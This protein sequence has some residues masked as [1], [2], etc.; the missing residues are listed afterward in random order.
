MNNEKTKECGIV[1]QE[2]YASIPNVHTHKE[3][4]NGLSKFAAW[5]GKSAD[6]ILAMRKDDLKL[7][8][9]FQRKRFE[10]ELEKFHAHLKEDG[11]STNTARTMCLGL[12]QFFNFY[13]VGMKLKRGSNVGKTV[14]TD[15]GYPLTIEDLRRMFA[16][17]SLRERVIL[18][19]AKDLGVRIG[20]FVEIRRDQLPD[21]NQEAPISFDVMTGK[22][23]V[24][25]KGHLSAETVEILKI[26][27]P[28]IQTNPNPH[29]FPT[30][31]THGI[32]ED[33]LG[34]ILKNLAVKAGILIPKTKQLTFHSFRKLFISTGKNVG[35]SDDIVKVLCGKSVDSDILTYMTGIQW[36]E[37]FAKI[38]DA[39]KIT[40]ASPKNHAR[41]EELEE[42]NRKLEDKVM[43]LDLALDIALKRLEE[44]DPKFKAKGAEMRRIM[45]SKRAPT[46]SKPE[47]KPEL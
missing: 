13:E 11:Y 45:A 9:T 16:V 7:E 19:L 17:A 3:Y 26:Y 4:K 36:R 43:T 22:E 38:A 34:L 1:E 6:E 47:F 42:R 14:L 33:T 12:M 5:Y 40:Q 18:S 41:L 35:V 46:D 21:L 2:F 31:G 20:D 25:A 39:L 8:D 23:E 29:L 10:R 30:N 28:T 24:I 15:K 32:D 27:L 37:N 44:L